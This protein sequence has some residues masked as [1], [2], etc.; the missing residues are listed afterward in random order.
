M[1]LS[2]RGVLAASAALPLALIGCTGTVAGA[3]ALAQQ[4]VTDA[5]NIEAAVAA[6]F[7]VT[8]PTKIDAWLNDA[9]TA[10]SALSPGQLVPPTTLSNIFN[11]LSQALT[12]AGEAVPGNAFIVSAQ[13]VLAALAAAWGMLAPRA[14]IVNANAP[15]L[16]QARAKLAALPRFHR[17]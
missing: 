12:A 13:I 16:D 15:T 2:R 1:V 10:L 7:N 3:I 6:A 11:D 17:G 4:A 14:A 5:E 8:I 9:E